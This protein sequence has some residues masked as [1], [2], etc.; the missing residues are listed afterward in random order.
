MPR[1][2]SGVILSDLNTRTHYR[3]LLSPINATCPAHLVFFGMAM[4]E[5]SDQEDNYEA[6]S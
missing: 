3:F 6:L 1:S 5:I 2:S 4:Q